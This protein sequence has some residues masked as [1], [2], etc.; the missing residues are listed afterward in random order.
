V[1][2]NSVIV[3]GRVTRAPELRYLPSGSPVCS[4]TIAT[5]RRF[6]AESGRSVLETTTINVD[7]HRRLGEICAQFLHKDREILV[8]GT[9]RQDRRAEPETRDARSELRILAE[10]VQFLGGLKSQDVSQPGE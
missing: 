6:T 1:S 8:M 7:A 3:I 2:F 5:S 9:L 10:T 4:F